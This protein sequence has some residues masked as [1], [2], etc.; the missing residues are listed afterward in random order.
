MACSRR[1]RRSGSS[2]SKSAAC[3]QPDAPPP[4][5]GR[6]PSASAGRRGAG[7]GSRHRAHACRAPCSE[8]APPRQRGRWPGSPGRMPASPVRGSRPRA[9]RPGAHRPAGQ[10]RVADPAS[11]VNRIGC[12]MPAHAARRQP[13]PRP[14]SQHRRRSHQPPEHHTP[15]PLPGKPGPPATIAEALT[16]AGPRFP[17]IERRTTMTDS[18]THGRTLA[19]RYLKGLNDHDPDAVDGFVAVDYINHN[20]FV[21]DGREANRAFWS[22]FF[23]AFPDI[24][25]TMDDLVVAGDRVVGRFTYRGTHAGPL[26]GIPPTGN[27]IEMR[28]IDIWRTENGEF[29]EH[30]DELNYLELFQQIGVIPA[31][32]LGD[33]ESTT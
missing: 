26:Y 29:V 3:H 25:A 17:A 33:T 23:T 10:H 28:S 15:A 13:G 27:P 16:T 12:V 5:T 2:C 6:P 4:A 8:R 14:A 31:F 19:A 11:G 32:N 7:R 24:E 22:S 21:E 30:W 1:S 18:Q 20:A 9:S